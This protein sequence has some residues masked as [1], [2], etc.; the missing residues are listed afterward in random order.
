MA[1]ENGS[2]AVR[3][4]NP[5]QIGTAI[6]W[7]AVTACGYFAGRGAMKADDAKALI[8]QLDVILPALVS[9]VALVWGIFANKDTNLMVSASRVPAVDAVVTTRKLARETLK[10]EPKVVDAASPMAPV[11]TTELDHPARAALKDGTL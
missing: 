1:E 11:S 5:E 3:T 7:V 8:T 2:K 9:L 10:D 4:V 6:R